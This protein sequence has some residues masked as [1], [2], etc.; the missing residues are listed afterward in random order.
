M[1]VDDGLHV[2]PRLVDPQ[3]KTRRRIGHAFA[4]EHVQVAVDLD[5]V[6]RGGLV[7]AQA[8]APAAAAELTEAGAEA[9]EEVAALAQADAETPAA[10][11]AGEP[12]TADAPAEAAQDKPAA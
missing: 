11:E 5:E 6:G 3:V 12:V 2:G 7:E 9:P 4:R 8:E 1:S 10:Q